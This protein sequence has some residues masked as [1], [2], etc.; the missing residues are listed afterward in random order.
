MAKLTRRAVLISGGAAATLVAG[1][2]FAGWY[3]GTETATA[4][5]REAGQGF[6]DPRLS[7]LSFAIL[8]PNPHNMQ[9]WR[10]ALTG[11]DG[12]DVFCA[13]DRRLPETD[14]LDRQIVIGFGC[15]LETLSIAAA[16]SGHRAEISPFPD[17]EPQPR[18]DGRRV[19]SVRIV[20]EPALARDPLFAAIANRRTSRE[21]YAESPLDPAAVNRIVAAGRGDG[22]AAD[23]ML[24]QAA[25]ARIGVI[26]DRAFDIEYRHPPT[27]RESIIV[28][29][30][31]NRAISEKPDGIALPGVTMGL[32]G[33]AGIVDGQSLDTPGTTAFDSGLSM[34]SA[35]IAS[36]RG[37]IWLLSEGNS[38]TTQLASGRAWMRMCL[39]ASMEGIN[40]HPLSQALQEFAEMAVPYNEMAELLGGPGRT[41]Q[42]LARVGH[43]PVGPHAPRWPLETRLIAH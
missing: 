26:A 43:A 14:P 6:D 4:P 42:M 25:I 13:L 39:A 36:A 7:A 12:I 31:G 32:L 33:L 15:M 28:T 35:A 24:D 30:V 8:A 27:R 41:L 38:R 3:P 10:F 20:R 29:R 19:A 17:G 22:L 40:V 34:Y 5:W 2:G 23:A 21:R 11:S 37:M 16:Q 9:P 18:L 1:V